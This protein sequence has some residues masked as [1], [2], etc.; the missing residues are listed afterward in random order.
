MQINFKYNKQ[1]LIIC[2]PDNQLLMLECILSGALIMPF[3]Y[4]HVLIRNGIILV[5]IFLY[6]EP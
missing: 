5:F 3:L 4:R 6:H 1:F 2:L